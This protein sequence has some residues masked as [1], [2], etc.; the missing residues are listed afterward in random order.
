MAQEQAYRPP[1]SPS[2][3]PL[4]Q[5]LGSQA[6]AP[7]G[8]YTGGETGDGA[9]SGATSASVAVVTWYWVGSGV[10]GASVGEGLDSGVAG[11]SGGDGV[12]SVV[13]GASVATTTRGV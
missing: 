2:G 8:S 12:G 7:G 3:S 6:P 5:G 11:A 4:R 10:I 1:E 13:T 9:G